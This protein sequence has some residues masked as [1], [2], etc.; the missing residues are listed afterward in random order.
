M[1]DSIEIGSGVMTYA[2]C[3][4]D[5]FKNSKLIMRFDRHTDSIT[6]L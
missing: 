5:R 6:I 3:H 2:E 1:N 4:K